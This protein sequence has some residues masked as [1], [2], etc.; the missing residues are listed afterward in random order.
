MTRLNDWEQRGAA[1]LR[2]AEAR[3]LNWRDAHCAFLAADAALAVTGEDPAA[4]WRGRTSAAMR[5][6][7]A[8]GVFALVPY[9]EIAPAGAQRFDIA[10][11][12]SV[13][14]EALGVCLG[15]EALVYA[16]EGQPPVRIPMSEAVRAWR[17]E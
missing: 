11:F 6:Q 13:H 8:K 12:M 10:G 14:G 7:S 16:A 3:P 2:D 15:R 4:E 5:A 9:H 1:W 17:V